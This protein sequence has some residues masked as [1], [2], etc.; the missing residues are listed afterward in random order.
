MTT[1]GPELG[2]LIIGAIKRAGVEFVL[3]LPDIVTSEHVL[4]PR[5]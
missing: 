5:Y 1:V 2:S 3:S 4:W